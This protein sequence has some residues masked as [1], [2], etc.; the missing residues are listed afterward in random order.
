MTLQQ[1]FLVSGSTLHHHRRRRAAG[2]LVCAGAVLAAGLTAAPAQS[3]TDQACPEPFP[4]AEVAAGQPVSGLTVSQGTTPEPFTGEVV[5]VVED[6]VAPDFDLVV[7]RLQ[8]PALDEAGGVWGGMS[9]SPVYAAD[10]RLIGAVSYGLSYGSPSMVT[11]VTPA[12]YMREMLTSDAEGLLSPRADEAVALPAP[13]ARR[14]VTSGAAEP[15]QV[16]AGL[17]R[18]PMPFAVSG[19]RPA[20]AD[21]V[22]TT[23]PKDVKVYQAP[24]APVAGAGGTLV[25]GGNVAVSVAYGD[26]T[27]AG[28]GTVTAVCGDE[29]LAFGHRFMYTGDNTFAMHGGTTLLVQP[30]PYWGGPFKIVNLTAPLGTVD[31]DRMAGVRGV[32]GASPS[33]TAISSYVEAADRSRTGSSVIVYEPDL[34]YLAAW[35]LYIA[36]DRVFEAWSRGTGLLRWT[37]RGER[38]D[39]APFTYTRS[40]RFASQWSITDD[41]A[42]ELYGQLDRLQNNPFEDVTIT[43]VT[44]DSRLSGNYDVYTVKTVS[45][46]RDGRWTALEPEQTLR[47]RAG[48]AKRFKVALTSRTLGERSVVLRVPVPRRAAGRFGEVTFTGG[49][50]FGGYYYEES[51]MAA[52]GAASFDALLKKMRT[53]V[54]NDSIVANLAL[55]GETDRPLRRQVR[56]NTGAVTDGAL[57]FPVRGVRR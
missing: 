8:S 10:G 50:W 11:G 15:E 17:S 36:Q 21:E 5:G 34:P 3:A 41:S 20:K 39:G 13:I 47:L 44:T 31:T 51:G 52:A 33:G 16:A 48:T 56:A 24:A 40:D 46:R 6:Y 54:R 28:V 49:N 19:P 29:V 42:W 1:H 12:A 14:L 22:A 25:P 57:Y 2:V 18:L 38:A 35:H 53:A 45:V 43:E 30:D 27:Y 37:V 26:L 32:L 9:G 4:V 7:V 55:Y 23:L